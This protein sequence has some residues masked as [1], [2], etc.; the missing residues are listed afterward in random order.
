MP[1]GSFS[2]QEIIPQLTKGLTTFVFDEYKEDMGLRSMAKELKPQVDPKIHIMGK[3]LY[4][5]VAKDIPESSEA[6]F[7]KDTKF[8]EDYFTAP[9]YGQAFNI[10]TNDLIL[11]QQYLVGFQDP[12]KVKVRSSGDIMSLNER[13]RNAS[14]LCIDMIKRAEANQVR[15]I[16][17]TGTI[18]LDN[19]TTI[20][21]E[22]DS[23]NSVTITTANL[24]W[25][26]ANASTMKPFQD[27]DD[28]SV[29]IADRGNSN[30]EFF[31]VLGRTAY[32]AYVNSDDYKADSDQR[33]NFKV[34]RMESI[35]TSRNNNIPEGATYRESIMRGTVGII[36]IFTYNET[37]TNDSNTPVQWIPYNEVWMMADDNV[38]TRQP[39]QILTFNDLQAL[40]SKMRQLINLVPGGRGWLIQPEW[41]KFTARNLAMGVYRKFLTL[42]LTP[43]KTFTAITSD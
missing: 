37:F 5:P 3:I 32:K 34:Q 30:G 21:F 35:P 43:N 40:S 14:K 33:R 18:S 29:Q 28:W 1:V 31:T 39:I 20:D 13:V 2:I 12:S 24:K 17:R 15:N 42:A 8:S 7:I 26:I 36:H 16:L 41:Q 19:Y 6:P 4:R 27:L 11:N 9:E 23:G 25:T 22:R 38:I 10:T